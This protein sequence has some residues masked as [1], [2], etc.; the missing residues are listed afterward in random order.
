MAGCSQQPMFCGLASLL[1]RSL[2]LSLAYILTYTSLATTCCWIF[3]DDTP[4][5]SY[6]CLGLHSQSLTTRSVSDVKPMRG[7]GGPR[8]STSSTPPFRIALLCPENRRLS[9][10]RPCS[11][12]T[13]MWTLTTSGRPLTCISTLPQNMSRGILSKSLPSKQSNVQQLLVL[14]NRFCRE[15]PL[16]EQACIG[17][18]GLSCNCVA[19]WELHSIAEDTV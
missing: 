19:L 1:P 4:A 15:N 10:P 2:V 11:L 17:A 14:R 3:L 6:V 18:T 5:W 9:F 13:K 12:E 8:H 16:V 7:E